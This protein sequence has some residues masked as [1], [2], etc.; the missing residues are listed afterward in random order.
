MLLLFNR[1]PTT[2]GQ[3]E[4][5]QMPPPPSFLHAHELGC[6]RLIAFPLLQ[7]HVL[8][9]TLQ[10]VSRQ[11]PEKHHAYEDTSINT[12]AHTGFYKYGGKKWRSGKTPSDITV[13]KVWNEIDQNRDFLPLLYFDICSFW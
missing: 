5:G 7:P 3:S 12:H 8:A 2:V 13:V 6:F 1:S 10:R 4:L 11:Q 9:G